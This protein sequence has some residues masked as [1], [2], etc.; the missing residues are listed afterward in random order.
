N[1]E[2]QNIKMDWSTSNEILAVGGHKHLN[3]TNY[4][5]EIIF[6]NRRGE[7]LHRAHLPQMSLNIDLMSA[8]CLVCKCL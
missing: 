5:N 6:Y 8:T 3:D 7:F 1:T 4:I 2:L